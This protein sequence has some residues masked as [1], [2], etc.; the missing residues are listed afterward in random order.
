M[1][2]NYLF[3]PH[4]R[5]HILHSLLSQYLNSCFTDFVPFSSC[6]YRKGKF[7]FNYSFTARTE[8]IGLFFNLSQYMLNG[9]FCVK[10]AALCTKGSESNRNQFE[11]NQ[12]AYSR[13]TERTGRLLGEETQKKFRC[14]KSKPELL[15]FAPDLLLQV[16]PISVN[17]NSF[18]RVDQTKNTMTSLCPFF[19]SLIPS[20]P[21][22]NSIR[23]I[24]KLDVGIQPCHSLRCPHLAPSH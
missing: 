24:F 11:E 22:A 8:V 14:F 1:G 5:G 13:W 9:D 4:L 17:G 21:S 20:N 12:C 18:L 6:L 23:P 19:L 10:R 16:C 7:H 15:I 2:L 3:F